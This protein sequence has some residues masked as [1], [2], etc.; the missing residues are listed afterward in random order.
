MQLCK[1]LQEQKVK[2]Q[3]TQSGS[4]LAGSMASAGQFENQGDSGL[5]LNRLSVNQMRLELPLLDGRFRCLN[6]QWLAP[7]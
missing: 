5:R 6:Q 1:F 2:R 4:S 3:K 7:L